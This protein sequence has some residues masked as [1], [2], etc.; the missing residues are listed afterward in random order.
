MSSPR[1]VQQV[2]GAATLLLGLPRSTQTVQG[3]LQ[4][5]GDELSAR[6]VNL[7]PLQTDDE[8]EGKGEE[9]GDERE[10]GKSAS[11]FRL[12]SNGIYGMK[13]SHTT[14]V[15]ST[16]GLDSSGAAFLERSINRA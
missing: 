13:L 2:V 4:D 6:H 9:G 11:G 5:G 3:H 1:G 16:L 12:I 14:S 15:R 7:Y 10:G 8:L